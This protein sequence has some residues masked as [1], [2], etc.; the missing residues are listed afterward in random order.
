MSKVNIYE[1]KSQLSQLVERAVAGE[2]IVLS[3]YGKPLVRITRLESPQRQITFGLLKGQ[4][5][6]PHDFDA[7]LPAEVM[8]GFESD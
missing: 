2:E 4:L 7:P 6:I 8:A 3:R 1:A 5:Q